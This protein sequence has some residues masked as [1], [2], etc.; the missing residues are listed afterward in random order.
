MAVVVDPS[1]VAEFLKYAHEENLEAVEVAVVT[2]SPRLVLKWRGKEIVNISRAFLDTN[3]AHQETQVLVDIPSREGNVLNRREEMPDVQETWLNMLKDL[4]VCSQKGLVE[5]FDS[6]IGAGSVLMPYGGQFQM[7]ETQAMV[8]KVPVQNGKTN[9]VTM[10]SYG[11]DPY[12]SSW[13]PYLGAVYAVTESI[14]RIYASGDDYRKIRITFQEYFRSMTEDPSRWSQPFAAL[15]GAY[16]AQLGFGLPSIGGKDSMSGTFNDIDVPPTLVSFAVDV[17]KQQDIITPELKK[18]GNRLV[19][20]RLPKDEY[21]LPDY[22]QVMDLY[23]RLYQDIQAGRVVSAYAL[24]R[25]GIAAAVSKMAFGNRKGVKI[26]HDL[27]P[28]DFFAPG[29]GDLI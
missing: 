16:N 9:T 1:N 6:S 12:V 3:G 4:N 14:A 20:I 24:D 21:D 7:T 2:E 25:H 13:S 18:A 26:E 19:W 10:M 11:F 17:A 5:M 22:P 28:R 27:D 23:D 8:A 15:L 29:F